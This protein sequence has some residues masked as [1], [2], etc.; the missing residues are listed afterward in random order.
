MIRRKEIKMGIDK[1]IVVEKF[2]ESN[3]WVLKDAGG[4]M[5]LQVYPDT[6]TI[7]QINKVHLIR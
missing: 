2:D 5:L 4:I 1:K 7:F 3:F 6:T